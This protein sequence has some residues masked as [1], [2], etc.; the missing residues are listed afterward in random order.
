MPYLPLRS[1]WYRSLRAR[2]TLW[3]T[4]VL[5]FAVI[6]SLLAVREGLRFYLLQ[7]A[8]VV[9]N[10]EARELLLAVQRWYPNEAQIIAEM[11]QKAAGHADRDWYIR[12]LTP[13]RSREIYASRGGPAKS[14]TKVAMSFQDYRVWSSDT[15]RSVERMLDVPG[16]PHYF[17]R[18]GTPTHYIDQH[19]ARLTRI[20]VPVAL[21]IVILAPLG[22]YFL[23]D[24]AVNPL[25]EIIRTTERLRPS[26]LNERLPTRGVGDE[27]DQLAFKIN[28]FLDQIADHLQK[29]RDF[30]ANAAHELRS[31]LTAM[32]SSIEV[33]I[34]RPRSTEEYE[35]LL[36]NIEEQCQHLTSLVNQLLQ[37]TETESEGNGVQKHP[38]A[39]EEIVRRAV[40]MFA[41]VAEERGILISSNIQN[42][43]PVLG[44]RQQLRQLATNLIDNAIKFTGRGGKVIVDLQEDKLS[45]RV[46]FTVTDTGIGIS[47]EDLPRIFE[48]FFQVDRSRSRAQMAQQRG[49]GL[50]LCICDAIVTHHRGTVTVNSKLGQ[51][52]TFTVKLPALSNSTGLTDL[53]A[54]AM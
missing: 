17:V 14:L 13:D 1:R 38:V 54:D 52:T 28:E 5:L 12:W 10:D 25:Q 30:V 53:S 15:H 51:G 31:P 26:Q 19:I 33:T 44:N 47:E 32:L 4:G 9:L 27:L 24:R 22:G 36:F 37:L 11:E 41:P 21:F 49:N 7:E 18:V 50:G 46:V 16:I 45:Q 34:G 43:S 29:N 39:L 40:E 6:V 2:L 48:R 8:N 3:H 35:E 42:C 23:S 20:A